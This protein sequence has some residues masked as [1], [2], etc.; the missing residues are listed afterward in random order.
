[1]NNICEAFRYMQT[2]KG[3]L[4]GEISSHLLHSKKYC[5]DYYK[6][7]F[8]QLIHFSTHNFGMTPHAWPLKIGAPFVDSFN[9]HIKQTMSGIYSLLKK[10]LHQVTFSGGLTQVWTEKV[11]LEEKIYTYSRKILMEQEKNIT[12]E[13]FMGQLGIYLICVLVSTVCFFLELIY[14]HWSQM[15]KEA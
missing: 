15:N 3:I 4:I 13:S 1:M 11:L 10:Y 14:Y 12:F 5:S 9:K 7:P 8:K 2:Q 6:K